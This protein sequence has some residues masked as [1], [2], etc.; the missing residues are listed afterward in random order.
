MDYEALRS[1]L[2]PDSLASTDVAEAS[3]QVI[4]NAARYVATHLPER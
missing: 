1:A 4:D 3:A 2:A